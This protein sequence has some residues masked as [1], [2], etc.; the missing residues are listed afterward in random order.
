[1]KTDYSKYLSDMIFRVNPMEIPPEEMRMKFDKAVLPLPLSWHADIGNVRLPFN[2]YEMKK[3]LYDIC[4][5]PRMSTFTIGALTNLIVSELDGGAYVNV[6]VWHG[7]S[8]FCGLVN[9][10]DKR[11]VGV[12]NF[13]EFTGNDPKE[14]F[15]KKFEELKSD[16][17]EFYE[18]GYSDY[19]KEH[20]GKIGFYIYDGQHTEE[21]QL[22][23][24]VLAEPHFSE[25]CLILIDDFNLGEPVTQ[26]IESFKKQSKFHYTVL[27]EQNTCWGTHP[28][29]WNGVILLQKG[30]R[31]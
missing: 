20:K 1:M 23:G 9:N 2:D 11:C 30:K 12:D 15:Y 8:L 16:N 21:E 3:I 5:I 6:G 27:F 14:N 19:F 10:P 22:A 13:S 4:T 25:D 7:F 18:M 17:H 28:S 24:L 26:A 29:F 31:K